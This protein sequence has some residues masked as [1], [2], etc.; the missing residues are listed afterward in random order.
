MMEDGVDSGVEE[1]LGIDV[2]RFSMLI[3]MSIYI[4]QSF[5]WIGT[6]N[7][8]SPYR[9]LSY[10]NMEAKD[11]PKPPCVE[12][13][14]QLKRKEESIYKPTDLS[15]QEDDSLFLKYCP[16][17][18]DRCYHAVSRDLSCRPHE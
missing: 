9:W 4:R 17:K 5:T 13:I 16:S 10:P 14:P 7:L 12:N 1:V 18:R 2:L 11:R 6:Y 15:T 8:H 3:G